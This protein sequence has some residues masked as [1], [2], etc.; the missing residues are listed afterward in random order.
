MQRMRAVWAGLIGFVF[1]AA[2]LGA[3]PGLVPVS[4]IDGRFLTDRVSIAFQGDSGQPELRLP[5]GTVPLLPDDSVDAGE[6]G[7]TIVSSRITETRLRRLDLGGA[8]QWEARVEPGR[9]VVPYGNA[10]ALLP[11]DLH[12]PGVPYSLEI[13]TS[14]GRVA[15]ERPGTTILDVAALEHHLV[16]SW[17]RVGESSPAVA[18]VLDEQGG[19]AWLFEAPGAR[20]PRIAVAGQ[21][22]AAVYPGRSGSTVDLA[23]TGDSAPSRLRLESVQLTHCAFATDDSGVLA[24]GP[25]G[26]VWIDD[27]PARVRW[28]TR[29]PGAARPLVSTT[30]FVTPV[31]GAVGLVVREPAAD[32]N[33]RTGLLLL[34]V[35]RGGIRGRI[36]LRESA[37]MP[38]AVGRFRHGDSERLALGDRLYEIVDSP[39]EPR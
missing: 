30:S 16:V 25:R 20:P 15:R 29:L 35:A 22:A 36:S 8:V 11:V 24:W 12:E 39:R 21:R 9:P 23:R 18:E 4:T 6:T 19:V 10:A 33:W 32:G 37:A 7:V 34:D 31:G 2:T 14:A 38:S 13:L 28:V 3:E 5:R 27:R 17:R 1:V 26:A